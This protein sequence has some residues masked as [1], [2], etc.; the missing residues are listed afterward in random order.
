MSSVF[1]NSRV[2]E[3]TPDGGG[4][5]NQHVSNFPSLPILRGSR[6]RMEGFH[7][8]KPQGADKERE[9]M[10]LRSIRMKI[11]SEASTGSAR[12]RPDLPYTLPVG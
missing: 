3:H 7:A 9:N 8:S 5:L 6:R 10:F 1:N 2:S 4:A 12:F 11:C